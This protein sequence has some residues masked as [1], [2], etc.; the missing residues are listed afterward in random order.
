MFFSS[1]QTIH[2]TRGCWKNFGVSFDVEFGRE[3]LLKVAKK[4]EVLSENSREFARKRKTENVFQQTPHVL[5]P[6][7]PQYFV[8]VSVRPHVFVIKNALPFISSLSGR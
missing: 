2:E 6:L 4:R 8:C 3:K 5:F 1:W 7:F